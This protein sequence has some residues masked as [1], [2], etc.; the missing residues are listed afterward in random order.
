MERE[1]A[2]QTE[3]FSFSQ[4]EKNILKLADELEENLK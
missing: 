4:A 2:P 1:A 3:N